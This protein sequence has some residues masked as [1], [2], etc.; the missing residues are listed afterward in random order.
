MTHPL[1]IKEEVAAKKIGAEKHFVVSTKVV[2]IRIKVIKC[3]QLLKEDKN[4]SM[5]ISK[6]LYITEK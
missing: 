6:M 5:L 4:L 2:V 3:C 1:Q